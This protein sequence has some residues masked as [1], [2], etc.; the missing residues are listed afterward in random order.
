MNRILRLLTVLL[1]VLAA[2]GCLFSDDDDENDDPVGPVGPPPADTGDQLM[3]NFVFA[4]GD[5]GVVDYGDLLHVDFV[6]HGGENV[7]FD[8]TEEL[9][10]FT[11]MCAGEAGVGGIAFE[12]IAL[13]SLTAVEV[14]QP[15]PVNNQFF[16]DVDGAMYRGYDI[17]I[18]Y[19][20]AGQALIYQVRGLAVFYAVNVGDVWQLLGIVDHTNGSKSTEAHS[21]TSVRSLFD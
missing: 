12:D 20:V 9:A 5:C 2:G 16:G 7:T 15:V 18:D 14:W 11:A 6:F 19:K 4:Y 3:D 17:A 21:W 8:R 13:H 1:L 10:T